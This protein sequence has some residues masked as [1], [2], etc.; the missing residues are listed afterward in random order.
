MKNFGCIVLGLLM[1]TP[2]FA[3]SSGTL[4][5]Q[6]EI[7]TKS[8]FGNTIRPPAFQFDV[9][10][11][12]EGSFEYE[13]VENPIRFA[14]FPD[15]ATQ[16]TIKGFVIHMTYNYANAGAEFPAFPNASY[17]VK[18]GRQDSD[19]VGAFLTCTAKDLK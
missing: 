13:G 19:L 17:V 15:M 9:M 1:S 2:A 10:K 8:N 16:K 12:H 5:C 7:V 11:G 4:V 14:Y 6:F 3:Y 18:I